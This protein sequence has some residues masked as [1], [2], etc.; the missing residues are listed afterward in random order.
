MIDE[1]LAE[2]EAKVKTVKTDAKS[3]AE[4]KRLVAALRKDI[5]RQEKERAANAEKLEGLQ[6]SIRELGA[7]H[8]QLV[9]TVD[10]ICREL[11]ALGI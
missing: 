5:K 6:N 2:L 8:P 1:T 4:L 11:A 7:S 3:K 10:T 9:T